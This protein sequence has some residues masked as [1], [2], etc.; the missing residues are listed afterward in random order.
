M[1]EKRRLWMEVAQSLIGDPELKVSCPSCMAAFLDVKDVPFDPAVPSK[2][3]ERCLVCR[4]CGAMDA[5]LLRN[6]P[7][8]FG[9]TRDDD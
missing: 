7:A 1:D 6:P 2:G 8:N 5:I 3:G 9:R 4:N